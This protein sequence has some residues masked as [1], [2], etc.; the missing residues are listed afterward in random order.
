MPLTTAASYPAVMQEFISHWRSVKATL[1]T[2]TPDDPVLLQGGYAGDDL[3]ADRTNLL[4]IINA[5]PGLDN[6]R[7]TAAVR[8]HSRPGEPLRNVG[9]DGAEGEA[10]LESVRQSESGSLRD[11]LLAGNAIHHGG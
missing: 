1:A 11:P 6:V 9:H 10:R 4:T 3:I 2:L 8:K 7:S 5:Q